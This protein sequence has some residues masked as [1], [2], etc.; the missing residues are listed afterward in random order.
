MAERQRQGDMATLTF[1]KK[2]HALIDGKGSCGVDHAYT[3]AVSSR[4][5]QTAGYFLHVKKIPRFPCGLICCFA[6][7]G[8]ENLLFARLV[9]RKHSQ[10]LERPVFAS[11][12]FHLAAARRRHSAL[13]CGFRRSNSRRS[14]RRALAGPAKHTSAIQTREVRIR[15]ILKWRLDRE[16]RRILQ[17]QGTLP[18][19]QLSLHATVN[20][21]DSVLTT[22]AAWGGDPQITAV[23]K[24]VF[25]FPLSNAASADSVI[26]I[27]LPPGS[28]T[29]IAS[30]VSGTA[31]AVLVEVYEVP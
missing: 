18:D 23:D 2:S 1:S 6:P 15:Q 21:Q 11:V 28:Y 19:P 10:W 14:P 4:L 31:G 27:T 22:N 3:I 12:R 13:R 25:A 7:G 30:S 17:L 8:V 9:R 5:R 26:L 24:S 29:A 16:N 20:G